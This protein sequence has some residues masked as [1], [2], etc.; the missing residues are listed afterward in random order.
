MRRRMGR[1]GITPR[2]A[3]FFVF[4]GAEARIEAMGMDQEAAALTEQPLA[5][6][7]G[8]LRGFTNYTARRGDEQALRVATAFAE[9]VSARLCEH[10]GHL[11]KTY[12]DGVMT[13]FEAAPNAASCAVAI[14]RALSEHNQ[15]HKDEPMSAGIGLAWG[16]AIRTGGDLFG[17]SVNFAKRLADVAKGGQIVVSSAIWE[18]TNE[19]GGLR[20]RDLGR[21]EIKG[22]GA[23]RLYELVWRDE[24]AK[25]RLPDNSLDVVLTRDQRL[26]LEFAKPI[27]DRLKEI[28]E[29]LRP[30]KG[31]T[32]PEADLR[33]R[34]A[35]RLARDL[36]KWVEATRRWG[37]A[38]VDYRLDEIDA[39]F[40]NGALHVRLPDDKELSFS[41]GQI[42]PGEAQRFLDKLHAQ[43][44]RFAM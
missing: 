27:E 36:P 7:F 26:V 20:Y 10:H 16:P 43:R 42:D 23:H 13:S 5:V 12:G 2:A 41:P 24:L 19:E 30:R 40:V 6:G 3:R 29:K 11:L 21:Q 33:Q 37:G 31:A 39:R 14:Q 8:D 18:Q 1:S 15:T 25:L 4:A 22:L 34:M 9:L 28:H 35:A 44:E 32:G 17:H 38:G